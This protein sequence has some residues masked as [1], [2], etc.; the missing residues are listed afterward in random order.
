MWLCLV[1]PDRQSPLR[2][3]GH[4]S[5]LCRHHTH[6]LSAYL[7]VHARMFWTL[8]PAA[9]SSP[10]PVACPFCTLPCTHDAPPAIRK[11]QQSWCQHGRVSYNPVHCKKGS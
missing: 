11:R 5:I 8:A 6:T 2:L 4:R 7:G 9:S 10:T 3:S 1:Y